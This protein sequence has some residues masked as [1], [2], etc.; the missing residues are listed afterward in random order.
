MVVLL[1]LE[2]AALGIVASRL[3]AVRATARDTVRWLYGT[4]P[5]APRDTAATSATTRSS[6]VRSPAAP[7]R[8]TI[9]PQLFGHREA[10]TNSVLRHP[11]ILDSVNASVPRRYNG[12]VGA[13]WHLLFTTDYDGTS[14]AHLLHQCA[15]DAAM[16]VIVR[17]VDGRV[18]GAYINELLEATTRNDEWH[19]TGECFLFALA[20][21]PLPPLPERQ[22]STPSPS[23]RAVTRTALLPF[24]WQRGSNSQFVRVDASALVIGAGGTGGVGLLLDSDLCRGASGHTA[25]FG[26]PP[27]PAVASVRPALTT[28]PIA[29][30]ALNTA[31]TAA[32]TTAPMASVRPALTTAPI[33]AP[34]AA[35]SGA[36]SAVASSA[37]IGPAS[38]AAYRLSE[39]RGERASAV[40][41]SVATPAAAPPPRPGTARRCSPGAPLHT[42]APS[43]SSASTASSALSASSASSIPASVDRDRDRDAAAAGA[44]PLASEGVPEGSIEF[45]VAVVESALHACAHHGAPIEFDV[46]FVEVWGLDERRALHACAH[47]GAL[48]PP[49]R[50]GD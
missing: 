21:V 49:H 24:R 46:A 16:L 19:G 6:A 28:A 23:R 8:P 34:N 31:P 30:T 22:L 25:T 35:A 33:A 43:A 7:L 17:S 42:P 44:A 11:A 48:P 18:F 41:S 2:T 15:S 14:L 26:N 29:T 37:S 36:M 12:E 27:L 38:A 39:R 40:V 13:H 5:G 3:P 20:E 10:A 4:E 45:D 9:L 50:C 47:H 1:G 32:L